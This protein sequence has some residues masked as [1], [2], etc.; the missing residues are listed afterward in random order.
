MADLQ[1]LLS[2]FL[3]GLYA[4]SVSIPANISVTG[5]IDAT[6]NITGTHLRT[7]PGSG[8]IYWLG[9]SIMQS[10]SDG[11]WQVTNQA[12]SGFTRAIFGT[13]DGTANGFSFT[14]SGGSVLLKT[15][16][17]STAFANLSTAI[18]NVC[19][20]TATPAAGSTSAVL[21]FGTTAGFGIYYGSNAPTV[22]AAQ[23]SLYLRSDGSSGTTRAYINT[24]GSTGWTNISTAT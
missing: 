9:R 14:L 23:G 18:T 21:L 22:S 6:G 16:D 3:N 4:G 12:Q 11:L 7:S 1:T 15:G 2:Y 19:A 13:N 20:G 17:G 10:P 5:T 24:N 8:Q